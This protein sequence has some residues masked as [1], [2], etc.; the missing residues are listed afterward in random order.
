VNVYLT[1]FAKSGQRPEGVTPYSAAVYQPKGMSFPK[2]EWTDIRAEAGLWIRP[3]VFAGQSDPLFRYAHRLYGLYDDRV[4]QAWEWIRHGPT[5]VALLCWCPYDKAARRQLEEHG[6]FVCHLTAVGQWLTHAFAD[7]KVWQDA[8]R[9][10]AAV[11]P[12]PDSMSD[13]RPRSAMHPAARP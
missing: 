10:R 9:L 3:R 8:D 2:V 13:H 6:S 1:S 4:D 7:V 5:D 11:L 12:A